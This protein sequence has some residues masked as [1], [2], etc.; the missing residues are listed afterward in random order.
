VLTKRALFALS[1]FVAIF[2][3]LACATPR[4]VVPDGKTEA[5][6][7]QDLKECEYKARLMYRESIGI[8]FVLGP[9]GIDSAIRE[10]WKRCM[11]QKGYKYIQ[12]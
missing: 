12:E 8:P 10:E 6:Y 9:E 11:E 3:L 7:A 1:G 5:D 4:F 2:S